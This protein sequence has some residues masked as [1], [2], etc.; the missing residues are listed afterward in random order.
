MQNQ[1]ALI[2][3]V[4]EQTM[5]N[6]LSLIAFK[7]AKV[8]YLITKPVEDRVEWIVKAT[9]QAGVSCQYEKIVMKKMPAID[10]SFR[11]TFDAIRRGKGCN[12][13]PIVNFTG[14]TKMISIGAY[15][16]AR[17]NKVPSVYVDTERECFING[18]TGNMPCNLNLDSLW[19]ETFRKSNRKITVPVILRANG[20]QGEMYSALAYSNEIYKAAECLFTIYQDNKKRDGIIAEIRNKLSGKDR[21]ILPRQLMETGIKAGF[22][23]CENDKCFISSNN[24]FSHDRLF[25]SFFEGLW[26]EFFV[27]GQL[28]STNKFSD[29]QRGVKYLAKE[30]DILAVDSTKLYFFSCKSGKNFEL[31]HIYEVANDAQSLGGRFT[32]K[33]LCCH[34]LNKSIQLMENIRK[35]EEI[36]GVKV[37]SGD[38][39]MHITKFL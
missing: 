37:L 38:D 10:E 34:R 30:W 12:L 8:I 27:M 7:P 11:T 17:E 15:S 21:L 33:Y 22:F 14:G 18:G 24:P 32:K 35:L 1:I 3:I 36:T 26:L 19:D 16:A 28:I 39:L 23:K 6:V 31:S 20:I 9:E 13:T 2:Q 4:S 29:I 25:L 5:Q